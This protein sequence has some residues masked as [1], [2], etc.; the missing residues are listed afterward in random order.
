MQYKPLVAKFVYMNLEDNT[1]RFVLAIEGT[2]DGL[3][4]WDMEKNTVFLSKKFKEMLFLTDEQ[5][6]NSIE[7]LFE[8]IHPVDRNF[9]SK[10]LRSHLAR[11]TLF[12][13]EVK[14]KA[15][16][17]NYEWFRIKGKALWGSDK[18]IRMAGTLSNINDRKKAEENLLEVRNKLKLILDN[19]SEGIFG[20]DE[21][22][23]ITF[24]N[25]SAVKILGFSEKEM[26]G[27][28]FN[29][30]FHHTKPDGSH[31]SDDENLILKSIK[32]RKV[33]SSDKEIFWNKDS[34]SFFVDYSSTPVIERGEC[35]GAVVVFKDIT[36]RKIL[37]RKLDR[38][39]SDL[40]IKN[41][42][43][44]QIAYHDTL[45]GL[46]NR[47]VFFAS[48]RHALSRAI[49]NNKVMVLFY[50]DLD[51]FKAINDTYGH[52]VGD[53]V[54]V[55]VSKRLKEIFRES[56]S[57]FRLGG[58]EFAVIM[59]GVSDIDDSSLLI[60]KTIEKISEPFVLEGDE[61]KI[62]CSI[63]VCYY[64][65][66]GETPE[67]LVKNADSAMYIAKK[68]SGNTFRIF[69]EEM[70]SKALNF[71]ELKRDIGAAL[72]NEEFNINY[73]PKF[74]IKDNKIS[75]AEVLI[76][77]EHPKKGTITP[78]TFIPIAEKAELI[79]EISEWIMKSIF[80]QSEKWEKSFNKKLSFA[81]KVSAAE[82]RRNNFEEDLFKLLDE[83]NFDPQRLIIEITE[84]NL[85]GN[86]ARIKK[87]IDSLRSKKI[88]VTID[89]FGSGDLALSI[90]ESVKVDMI[91][92][93]KNI[94]HKIH[95]NKFSAAI[96]KAMVDVAH[97]SGV[98][99]IA[100]GVEEKEQLKLLK[101]FG[102][103]EAQGFLLGKPMKEKDMEKLF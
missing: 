81:V 9:A 25:E 86:L 16:K 5:I 17:D 20:I 63:G 49:R 61:K 8:Y 28:S 45:T 34:T 12:D 3:W 66:C 103:D 47:A 39:L 29:D 13:I 96:V 35:T 56:D 67:E 57:I 21:K 90:L 26:I 84:K 46:N 51:G 52:D 10:A 94:I 50:I 42:E 59:E 85:T 80:A 98:K 68:E 2:D 99:V 30:I 24:V 53:E 15:K 82:L 36:E 6:K 19:A 72:K 100:E 91:K 65:G 1:K 102:A 62:G 73:Q 23:N 93:D 33:Y 88:K 64:P 4:D 74:T 43:L 48:I 38:A 22:S 58:D 79:S 89:D 76:R 54:L 37:Q 55:I 7:E 83:W 92:I 44:K 41:E 40:Q 27:K 14:I 71:S 95:K 11:N 101:E 87:T 32:E 75:S 78:S 77:W 18:P 60:N 31:Y 69:A 97:T 70:N